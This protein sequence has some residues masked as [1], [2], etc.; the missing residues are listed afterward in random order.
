MRKPYKKLLLCFLGILLLLSFQ[1]PNQEN[2]LLQNIVDQLIIY[3]QKG[4][5]EK[6]YL[7]TDKDLYTNGETIWF[8]TY[9]IDGITHQESAK[10]KVAYVELLDDND[11]IIEQ[12]KLYVDAVGASGDI[13]IGDKI[14]QGNYYL[15]SYTKYMLNSKEP[16]FFEKKISIVV[17][18]IGL[19]TNLENRVGSNVMDKYVHND[20][21]HTS[22]FNRPNIRFFPEGGQ[23][24]EGLSGDLGIEVT[25][26]KGIGIALQGD[27]KDITGFTV[28]HFESSDFGLGKINFMP[29]PNMQYYA[30][31]ILDRR[32]QK[33]ALP[34]AITKGYGLSV[35]NRGDNILVQVKSNT[36]NGVK[37]TLLIGH[38]RG[39]LIFE[40][41]GQEEDKYSY[42]VKLFTKELLDGVAQFTLFTPNG[43]PVCERLTFV[44]NPINDIKLYVLSASKNYGLREKVT[45]DIAVA[46]TEGSP[47]KG[48][49]AMGVVTHNNYLDDNTNATNI[50]SWLL[51]NSDLGGTVQNAGYFFKDDSKERKHLL[52]ALMLTHGWRRFVWEDMLNEKESKTFDFPAEKGIMITGRTTAFSNQDKPKKTLATLSILGKE[53]V[54]SQKST[55]QNGEFSFGPFTYIDSISGVVQAADTLRKRSS[56]QKH[57]SVF[58]DSPWP[59][60]NLKNVERK[61]K[62]QQTIIYNQEYLKESYRKKIIDFQYDPKITQLDEVVVKENRKTKTQIINDAMDADMTYTTLSNRVYKDSIFGN[63]TYSALELL[64][65]VAGVQ[66]AGSYPFQSVKVRGMG[67]PLFLLD[68][69]AVDL[70]VAQ[71]MRANEV[72]LIDVVKGPDAALWGSRGANGVVAIYTDRGFRF[73]DKPQEEVPGITNFKLPGFNKVREFYSPNYSIPQ[74]AHEKPDYR[75]T[76]FWEPNIELDEN[77][78]SSVRFH[79]GDNTGKYTVKIEG[80]TNDGRPIHGIHN[81]EVL[82]SN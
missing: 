49:F 18:K 11:S 29:S 1:I 51:L 7:H 35:K 15:R 6:T 45:M 36:N 9:L 27:I 67:T 8:K 13:Q 37:G 10:S 12:R 14:A 62:G 47:L 57:V 68:G 20:E 80:I 2:Q 72:M 31:I 42:A 66:V 24:V 43:E 25:N 22:G 19:D 75:T 58:M 46:D 63:S 32:E 74:A 54:H 50:K 59:K 34:Q 30:S 28:S 64:R 41:I 53:I 40:R 76:L 5:A 4:G 82:E 16:V 21:N 38:L 69:F 23:M 55:N 61:R 60:M 77:G 44:N 70:E 81:I 71:A 17:Q 26:T 33:F 78:K 52:D 65:R 73:D 39:N 3:S 56:M 48:N 79:T